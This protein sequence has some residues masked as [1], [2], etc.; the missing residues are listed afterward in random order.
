MPSVCTQMKFGSLPSPDPKSDVV[1]SP[2]T[3]AD[4]T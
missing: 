4:L 3:F 1:F 2:K